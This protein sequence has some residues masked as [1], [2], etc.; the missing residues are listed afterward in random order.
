MLKYKDPIQL[1]NNYRQT[2]CIDDKVL[3]LTNI[4]RGKLTNIYAINTKLAR[5]KIIINSKTIQI[6]FDKYFLQLFYKKNKAVLKTIILKNLNF[7]LDLQT[8]SS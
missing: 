3:F 2:T 8:L 6:T 1:I 7:S 5:V 4:K